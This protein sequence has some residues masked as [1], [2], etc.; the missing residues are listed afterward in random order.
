MVRFDFITVNCAI[1]CLGQLGDEVNISWFFIP[2]NTG[3]AEPDQ[4]VLCHLTSGIQRAYRFD[5]F[6]KFW[7]QNTKDTHLFDGIMFK[8]RFFHFNRKY[9]FSARFDQVSFRFPA[10]KKQESVRIYPAEVSGMVPAP[11]EGVGI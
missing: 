10:F 1:V 8:N 11:L 7:I 3:S 4:I 2:G 5:A 6:P 9:I